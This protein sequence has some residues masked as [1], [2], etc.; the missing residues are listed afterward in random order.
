MERKKRL[1]YLDFIRVI[2]M[3]IIVTYHFFA[4][5]PENNITGV[6]ITNDTWGKVGVAMFFMLSGASLMYNYKDKL[7]LKEYAVKRFKGIYPMF[8]IAYGLLYIYLFLATKN[9][10]IWGV[11]PAKFLF[12]LVAMDGYF[13]YYT[14][15]P[16]LLGEWFLGC[17]VISYIL[18][19]LLRIIVNKYPKIVII[20]SLFIYFLMIIFYNESK[21]PLDKTIVVSIFAFVLGMYIIKLENIKWW[22][23]AVATCIGIISCIIP[24]QN[25]KLTVFLAKLSGYCL[26][27]VLA[28]LGQKVTNIKIQGLFSSIGKYSYAIFLVHHYLILKLEASFKNQSY[29]IGGTIIL[30]LTCWTIIVIFARIIHY[31]NRL[32][33]NIFKEKKLNQV[34]S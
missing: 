18:F 10:N 26:F 34:S 33:L 1:F 22:Y 32:F 8:W 27:V 12:S 4:H 21:V 9:P 6:I 2:S 13:G 23:M 11:H 31:I 30:Y 14:K 3:V 24:S 19:P 25:F 5:F 16:Y 29:G 17:I 28:Y 15:T 7:S 20:L